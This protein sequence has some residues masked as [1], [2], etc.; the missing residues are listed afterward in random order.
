MDDLFNGFWP[1]TA[2]SHFGRADIVENE[3][4]YLVEIDLPGLDKNDI[5]VEVTD[6]GSLVVKADQKAEQEEKKGYYICKERR[7]S[8]FYRT[9]EFD[10]DADLGSVEATYRDGVLRLSVPK[11]QP[12]EDKSRRVEII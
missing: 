9:F 2:V 11:R 1:V 3:K 8:Q 6:G 4:E 5:V 12:P 7:M 10:S